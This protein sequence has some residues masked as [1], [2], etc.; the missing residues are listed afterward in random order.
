VRRR[1][2]LATAPLTALIAELVLAAT[3]GPSL[4]KASVRSRCGKDKRSASPLQTAARGWS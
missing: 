2:A 3:S 4:E 1:A